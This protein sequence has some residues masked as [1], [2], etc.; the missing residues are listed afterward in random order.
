MWQIISTVI[1]GW[2][3]DL[4]FQKQAFE[5]HSLNGQ[6]KTVHMQKGHWLQILGEK[7]GTMV[8]YG[9]LWPI[10]PASPYRGWRR[11]EERNHSSQPQLRIQ[12]HPT[13][14][15]L[16]DRWMRDLGGLY[17]QAAYF[18]G[19]VFTFAGTALGRSCSALWTIWGW[20]WVK[21]AKKCYLGSWVPFLPFLALG[22]KI[23]SGY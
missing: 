19:T 23:C 12:H 18:D 1:W 4:F 22:G 15:F 16:N 5:H 10:V 13:W 7:M 6:Q 21:T 8:R 17:L 11:R 3:E 9:C 20:L 14:L 2:G